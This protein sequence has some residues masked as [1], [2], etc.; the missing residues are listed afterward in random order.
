MSS[1]NDCAEV[2]GEKDAYNV[3]KYHRAGRGRKLQDWRIQATRPIMIRGESNINRMPPF[4]NKN[5]Q[6][7]SYPGAKFY[8]FIKIFGMTPACEEAKLVLLSLGL[9]NKDLDTYNVSIKHLRGMLR[10][11]QSV[12][13]NAEIYVAKIHFSDLLTALQKQN[14]TAINNFIESHLNYLPCIPSQ[15]FRTVADEIHW[16]EETARKIFK[17]WCENLRLDEGLE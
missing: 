2:D 17:S 11:A 5:I 15:Q 7:D 4:K 6:V 8:H 10:E 1:R 9:N 13:P 14:L 16:S 12:F 3:P